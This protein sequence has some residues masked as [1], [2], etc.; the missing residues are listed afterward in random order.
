MTQLVEAIPA[1]LSDPAEA[2]RAWF[3]ANDEEPVIA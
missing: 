2:A 3:S 1:H